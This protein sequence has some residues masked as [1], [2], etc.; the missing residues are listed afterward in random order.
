[1]ATLLDLQNATDS[2]MKRGI[3]R[4]IIDTSAILARFSFE[5]APSLRYEFASEGDLPTPAFRPLN[6]AYTDSEGEFNINTVQLKPFG[7]TFIADRKLKRQPTFDQ[8]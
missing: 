8:I 5:T 3:I 2:D 6:K 4:N 7:G 1:M